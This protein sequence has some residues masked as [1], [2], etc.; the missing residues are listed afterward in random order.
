MPH[1]KSS[2]VFELSFKE[3]NKKKHQ[4]FISDYF[5]QGNQAA[6]DNTIRVIIGK[7]LHTVKPDDLL[8]ILSGLEKA[9][10]ENSPEFKILPEYLRNLLNKPGLAQTIYVTIIEMMGNSRYVKK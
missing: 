1:Q 2:T 3:L 4:A 8:L 7:W 10:L 5:A 6:V 9:T